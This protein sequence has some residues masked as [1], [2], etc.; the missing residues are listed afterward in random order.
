MEVDK[1][2]SEENYHQA[3]NHKCEACEKLFV[4]LRNLKIHEM[5]HTGEKLHQCDI[6][7]KYFAQKSGLTAHKITHTEKERLF[8]CE[9][10]RRSFYT[11]EYLKKHKH[12]QSHSG[13]KPYK[14]DTCEM[15]TEQSIPA[16]LMRSYFVLISFL[17][18]HL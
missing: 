15:N 7:G 9:I 12:I 6:C 3:K 18:V 1:S 10:C 13:V 11:E 5:T 4:S 14:C 8:K 2:K 16:L 17:I